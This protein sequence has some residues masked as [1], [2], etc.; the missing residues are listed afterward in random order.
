LLSFSKSDKK[1][2]SQITKI[3][4]NNFTCYRGMLY[5]KNNMK[6]SII[7]F[8]LISFLGL[9]VFSIF[10][11]QHGV[12]HNSSDCIVAKTKGT[13]CSK[14]I[15]AFSVLGL[16]T[17]A[18]KSFSTAT[19]PHTAA[20][21]L[22]FLLILIFATIFGVTLM[23]PPKFAKNIQRKSFSESFI[24]PFQPELVSWMALHENSPTSL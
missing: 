24:F 8:I 12:D 6:V 3:N 18:F 7:I 21:M 20:N 22:P 9:T 14:E 17:G 13:D 16:H 11:M 19:V 2:L 5:S 15:S 23:P 4:K 10:A 1:K